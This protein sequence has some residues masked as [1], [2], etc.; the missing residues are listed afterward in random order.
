MQSKRLKPKLDRLDTLAQGDPLDVIAMMFWV[1]RKK[2]PEMYIKI[3]EK[4]IEAFQD[5]FQYLKVKPEVKIERPQGL[6]AQPAVPARHNRR[7]IPARAATSPK[8]YV[9]VSLLGKDEKGITGPLKAVE[10]NEA[11]Y[12]EQRQLEEVRRWRDRAPGIAARLVIAA[13]KGEFSSS[14]L[15][16]AANALAVL[17]RA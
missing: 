2:N 9:I 17:A 15:Q 5:C 13:A 6:P 1:N 11:D 16:E 8:P 7:E 14:D 3:E 12:H 10:N 4:D